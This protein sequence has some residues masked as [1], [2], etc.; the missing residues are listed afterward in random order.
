MTDVIDGEDEGGP[1]EEGKI[2]EIREDT[3]WGVFNDGS[4]FDMPIGLLDGHSVGT[5]VLRRMNDPD[6]PI[7]ED[8]EEGDEEEEYDVSFMLLG[9][10]YATIILCNVTE[11]GM[12]IQTAFRYHKEDFL[13]AEGLLN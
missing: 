7:F 2:T 13:K 8:G 5:T 4:T 6:E 9:P 10:E 12:E 3:F 11:E 1:H